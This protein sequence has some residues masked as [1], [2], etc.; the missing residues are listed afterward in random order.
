[1]GDKILKPGQYIK[2]IG[3]KKR[4]SFEM[5]DEYFFRYVGKSGDYLLFSVN[6]FK[7]DYYYAFGYVNKNTLVMCGNGKRKDLRLQI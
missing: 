3:E 6:D 4:T 5:N 1:M 7:S 2:K